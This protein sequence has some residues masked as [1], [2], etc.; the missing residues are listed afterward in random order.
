[1]HRLIS[2]CLFIGLALATP[3][4]MAQSGAAAKEP[5]RAVIS[6]YRVAPGKHVAFLKWMADRDA[7]DQQLGLPRAQWY[8]HFQ[9]DSWDYIAIAPDLTD[10]QQR[11]EDDAAKAK[12]LATGL[13]ASLEFREFIASHTDTVSI[14]PLT[15]SDLA[16]RAS[17]P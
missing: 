17:N 10:A 16:A 9:G 14:G 1:M 5:G 3:M 2:R 12:G 13:K 8:G 6:L 15:A 4:V 11:K 7:I